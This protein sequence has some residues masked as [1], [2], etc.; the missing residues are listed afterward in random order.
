MSQRAHKS[1]LQQFK[2]MSVDTFALLK[3]KLNESRKNANERLKEGKRIL[4]ILFRFKIRTSHMNFP[5]STGLEKADTEV[6]ELQSCECYGEAF[7][8]VQQFRN[9]RVLT[10]FFTADSVLEVNDF[11]R[12]LFFDKNNISIAVMFQVYLQNKDTITLLH[13]KLQTNS[14]VTTLLLTHTFIYVSDI[15]DNQHRILVFSTRLSEFKK[16]ETAVSSGSLITLIYI[17]AFTFSVIYFH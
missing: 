11:I 3:Q 6:S 15:A 17:F 16:S 9:R 7:M 4:G 2:Q 8:S 14:L 5:S 13:H 1:G 12:F 10:G